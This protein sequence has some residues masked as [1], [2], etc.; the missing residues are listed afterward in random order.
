MTE[1]ETIKEMIAWIDKRIK[2]LDGNAPYYKNMKESLKWELKTII[3]R[4]SD[5]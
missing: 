5:L 2:E 1:I 4:E 3:E